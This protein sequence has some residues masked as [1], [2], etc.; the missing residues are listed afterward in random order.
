MKL[1][2]DNVLL[3]PDDAAEPL[4][5]TPES[6]GDA[7]AIQAVIERLEFL[8][9][10]DHNGTGIK[11][12]ANVHISLDATVGIPAPVED[13]ALGFDGLT[14]YVASVELRPTQGMAKIRAI[15]YVEGRLGT[16][17]QTLER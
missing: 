6:T 1:D 3:N 16:D 15:L 9:T 10:F 4:T 7:R 11:K 12:E 14:Y 8:T 2:A 5:Y 13:D 17:N